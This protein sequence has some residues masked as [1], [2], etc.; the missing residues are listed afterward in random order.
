MLNSGYLQVVALIPVFLFK[1][2]NVAGF[3][4]I[5]M[6]LCSRNGFYC[7]CECKSSSCIW[8]RWATLRCKQIIQTSWLRPENVQRSRTGT[9][10]EEMWFFTVKVW[11]A[12][13]AEM[14]CW[15]FWVW[16]IQQRCRSRFKPDDFCSG[17]LRQPSPQ[18]WCSVLVDISGKV[19]DLPSHWFKQIY[20][21]HR[22]AALWGGGWHG[23]GMAPLANHTRWL[24]VAMWT[25][26]SRKAVPL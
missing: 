11:P 19:M 18:L 6:F 13:T 15:Y 4:S 24:V 20:R 7:F 25:N 10:S 14:T 26:S 5:H 2:I 8:G 16:I 12:E 17:G 21:S 3:M 9:A 1:Q 22:A 23:H